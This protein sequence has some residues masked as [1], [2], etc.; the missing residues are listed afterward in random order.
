[1]QRA[2]VTAAPDIRYEAWW[3]RI[4]SERTV[5]LARIDVSAHKID[6]SLQRW[7]SARRVPATRRAS[8][9]IF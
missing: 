3:P 5:A 1:M 2:A 9:A 6:A 8:A 7:D 4:L